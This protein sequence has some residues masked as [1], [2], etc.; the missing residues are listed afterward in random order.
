MRDRIRLG[1]LATASV[2][3][4]GLVQQVGSSSQQPELTAPPSMALIP[5]GEF[6]MGGDDAP[7]AGPIH[8]VQLDAFYMDTRE[9]TNA[10][11]FT[12]C[13]ATGRR[14]PFYWGM[15]EFHAGLDFPDYPVVGVSWLDAQAYAG[16]AGKR[17]PTEAEWEYAARGGLAG[18]NFPV[19]DDIDATGANF[20]SLGTVRVGSYAPNRFGLY[21]MAGNVG[22]WVAD[23]YDSQYYRTSP[24]RNPKGP[25]E[26]TYSVVRGGGWFAGK[27][28]NRVYV[29]VCLKQSWVDFNVGFRCAK[30]I[31]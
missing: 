21:D 15:H 12:F 25:T 8:S 6:L 11:Y 10:Q 4:A 14:L 31:R 17:L 30:D 5:G 1:V 20:S 9:V 28:C 22:E 3:I 23:R 26:G 19:G 7:D 13:Q 27:W 16:W 2:V 24:N 29:R 18:R